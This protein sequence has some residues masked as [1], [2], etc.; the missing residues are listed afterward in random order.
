MVKPLHWQEISVTAKDN[1]EYNGVKKKLTGTPC[2]P[3]NSDMNGK[4]GSNIL[5]KYN[6]GGMRKSKP[7]KNSLQNLF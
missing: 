7:L 2:K 1:R 5:F 6:D 4:A 3:F